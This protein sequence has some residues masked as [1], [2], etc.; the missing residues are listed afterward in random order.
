MDD[1]NDPRISAY[2]PQRRIIVPAPPGKKGHGP[3]KAE[4]ERQARAD[5]RA[6]RLH[7][8][9]VT[10]AGTVVMGV[11]FAVIVVMFLVVLILR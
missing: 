9:G 3:T 2:K 6:A 8:V 10:N 5:K 7:L 1:L 4:R 11:I